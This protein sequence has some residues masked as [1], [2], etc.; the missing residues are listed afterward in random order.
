MTQAP[1]TRTATG[2][3]IVAILAGLLLILHQDYWFWTSDL[4]VFGIFPIG[5]F[6]H[7]G[8]SLAAMMVWYLATCIAWPADFENDCVRQGESFSHTNPAEKTDGLS[9]PGIAEDSI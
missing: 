9:K 7:M 6:W 3:G 8:I 4:L 1:P 2:P 5:L